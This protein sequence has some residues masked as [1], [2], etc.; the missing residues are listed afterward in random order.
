MAATCQ[1]IRVPDGLAVIGMDGI[2][3]A[4]YSHPPLATVAQ[5]VAGLAEQAVHLAPHPADETVTWPV[6]L[7]T[8]ESCGCP[9][10][11]TQ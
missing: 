11:P 3:E 7:I 6:S 9:A 5:D 10:A 2:L 8:R 1:G 4:A